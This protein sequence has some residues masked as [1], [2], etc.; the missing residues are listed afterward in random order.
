[1]FRAGICTRFLALALCLLASLTVVGQSQRDAA[2]LTQRIEASR[3]RLNEMRQDGLIITETKFDGSVKSSETEFSAAFRRPNSFRIQIK[4]QAPI[5]TV[6]DGQ[7]LWRFSERSRSYVKRQSPGR[8]SA[9]ENLF[10][11]F[12]PVQI[13]DTTLMVPIGRKLITDLKFVGLESIETRSGQKAHCNVFETEMSP[14]A[15]GGIGQAR[16]KMWI[17]I[18]D[19]IT[20]K[21][22]TTLV[23]RQ[24]AREREVKTTIL[25]L[26]AKFNE[27][28]SDS[29][30]TFVPPPDAREVQK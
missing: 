4:G 28:L 27:G 8:V 21:V 29:F 11:Q 5:L 30:F 9:H 23:P 19:L 3:R 22:E 2:G 18:N 16:L 25:I 7:W 24:P 26:N 17:D 10:G 1:M 14:E 12:V 15:I 20:W 6:S 13:G